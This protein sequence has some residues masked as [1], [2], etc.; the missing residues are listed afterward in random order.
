MLIES[1]KK[2]Q[3]KP[4]IKINLSCKLTPIAR[5][6]QRRGDCCVVGVAAKYASISQQDMQALIIII[7]FR[8]T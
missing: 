5:G 1:K 7:N 2:P 3:H 6:S 4:L 8:L